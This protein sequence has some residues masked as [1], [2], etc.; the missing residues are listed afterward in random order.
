MNSFWFIFFHFT[1]DFCNISLIN[2][3]VVPFESSQW[4][5]SND[6]VFLF[7]APNL[8]KLEHLMLSR[9]LTVITDDEIY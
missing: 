1:I 8:K 9:V 3:K 4:G 2:T 7:V 5:D 6:I